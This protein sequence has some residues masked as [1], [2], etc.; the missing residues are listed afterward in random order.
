MNGIG[1]KETNYEIITII[2][3]RQNGDQDQAGFIGVEKE[4]DS[5]KNLKRELTEFA[6]RLDWGKRIYQERLRGLA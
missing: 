6:D 2:Q 5:A 1:S 3:V 4:S